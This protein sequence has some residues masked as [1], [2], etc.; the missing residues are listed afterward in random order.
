MLCFLFSL[1][2]GQSGAPKNKQLVYVPHTRMLE[3]RPQPGSSGLLSMLKGSDD[4]EPGSVDLR[5]VRE[6]VKGIQGEVLLR[7]RSR[8]KRLDPL[9]CLSIVTDHRTLDLQFSSSTERN[10]IF[11][12]L[13]GLV[14]GLAPQGIAG[15][16]KVKVKPQYSGSFRV[17][18]SKGTGEM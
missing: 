5:S 17:D 11:L 13:Q 8:D 12:A 6:V 3:W 18:R 7:A 14:E 1:Q 10:E 2:H 9:C 16:D 15:G 4:G